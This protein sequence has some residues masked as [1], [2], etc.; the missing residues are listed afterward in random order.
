MGGGGGGGGI[1]NNVIGAAIGFAVGGPAGAAIGFSAGGAAGALLGM[2]PTPPKP[3]PA[4][5]PPPAPAL[6]PV[7]APSAAPIVAPADPQNKDAQAERDVAEADSRRRANSVR[8]YNYTNPTGGMGDTS[9][10]SLAV[11]SLLGS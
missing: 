8:G 7:D 2:G 1:V 11:K 6:K 3:A 9:A 4:A 10:P 5:A